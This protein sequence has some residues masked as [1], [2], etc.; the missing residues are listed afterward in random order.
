MKFKWDKKYLYWGIT[1]FTVTIAV[2]I[3]QD[4]FFKNSTFFGVLGNI[5]SV[6]TPVVDGLVLAYLLNPV[7]DFF[8]HRVVTPVFLRLKQNVSGVKEKRYTRS[9]SVALTMA[10]TV[11]VVYILFRMLIPQ[12]ADSIGSVIRNFPT[13]VKNFTKWIEQVFRDNP[14][15]EGILVNIIENYS[16]SIDELFTNQILPG[17]NTIVSSL[18]SGVAQLL[19]FT[20]NLLIGLIISIYVMSNKEL[21]KA[22]AKKVVHAYYN[23]RT[24]SAIFKEVH[25]IHRTFNDFIVGKVIDSIIVGLI[26]F[27]ATSIL[28]TPYAVL[29]SVL[30]GVTNIIPF[31]GPFFGAIPSAILILMVNPLQCLY[32]LIMIL[33]LQQVDGNVIG[34]KILGDSTGISSFWVIFAI[35][36]AGG[37]FGVPGMFIGVPV[38]AVLYAEFRR[39][40]NKR[41]K[42]KG[43]SP[44]TA[45]YFEGGT[46][47][48]ARF[49]SPADPEK[50]PE[51]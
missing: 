1:A 43:F 20:W 32:F 50:M 36:V 27:I 11:F 34:P 3:F 51:K 15:I 38:F 21:F 6:M 45:D 5:W 17:V 25:F 18:S 44:K 30:V 47:H 12:L 39:R 46:V 19:R 8:E 2:M 7:L 42:K 24:A 22:Q 9:C 16:R 49:V 28:G 33:I 29:V 23:D 4:I 26:C 10:T 35:T 40:V 41:L 13:Y 31:F 14:E 48:P 37:L